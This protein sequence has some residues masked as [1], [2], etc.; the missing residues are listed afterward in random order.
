LARPL[1]TGVLGLPPEAVSVILF[2]FLRKDISIALLAPLNLTAWQAVTAS[3]FLVLYLP[4]LATFFVA[5]R[6]MGWRGLWRV[7]ALTLGW[8]IAVGFLLSLVGR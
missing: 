1:V 4:C 8:A 5:L 7:I 2:G 3:V 6:E